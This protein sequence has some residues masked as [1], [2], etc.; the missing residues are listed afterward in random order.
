VDDRLASPS[1]FSGTSSFI[2]GH[3][4]AGEVVEVGRN[5]KKWTKGSRVAIKPGSYCRKQALSPV[6][7]TFPLYWPPT[8]HFRDRCFDCTTGQHNLCPDQKYFGAPSWDGSC[9]TWKVIPEEQLAALTP[10]IS[11]VEAGLVQPLA[12]TLQMTRQAGLRAHQNVMIFGAGCI[13]LQLGAV[14]K[15]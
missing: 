9:C 11:W 6:P 3:E 13:G 8:N 14:A 5:V 10:R 12:I 2:L 15:A 4:C 1:K 7:P